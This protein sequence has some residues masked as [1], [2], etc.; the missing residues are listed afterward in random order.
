MQKIQINVLRKK[1]RILPWKIP[2]REKAMK[3]T[4]LK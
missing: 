4:I 2:E 1:S 3:L